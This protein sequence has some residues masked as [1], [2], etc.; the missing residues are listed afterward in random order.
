M[1]A[2]ASV[3]MCWLEKPQIV[4][5]EVAEWAAILCESSFF[6]VELFEF[7]TFL[8]LIIFTWS[9]VK[10]AIARGIRQ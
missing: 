3:E 4:P 10:S 2:T 9:L 5:V 8:K 7:G 6:K 1:D